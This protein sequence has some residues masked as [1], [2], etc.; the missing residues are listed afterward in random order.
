MLAD[1]PLPPGFDTVALN[2][3]GTNDPYQFGARVTSRV[4]CGWIA[5]RLRAKNAGDTAAL[6]RAADALRGSHEWKVLHQMDEQ[7]DW[8]EVFWETADQVA[9]GNPPAGYRLALGCESPPRPAHD[10]QPTT[11]HRGQKPASRSACGLLTM[12]YLAALVDFEA[13]SRRDDTPH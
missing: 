7:G 10:H 9:A 13:P 3:I 1:V 6:Q 2:D 12:V 4:G 5:E 11:A 8:P